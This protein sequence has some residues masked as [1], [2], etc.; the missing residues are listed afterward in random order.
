MRNRFDEQLM[1]LNRELIEMGSMCEEA[2]AEVAKALTTGDIELAKKIKADGSGIDHMERTIERRC[3][4]LLLHQQPV[5]RDL[6]LISAALKMITD[7]ERIGDMSE[8]IA[9]I[10]IELNGHAMEGM[11][12][13]LDMALETS[14]MVKSSVD[15][16]VKKDI[17]LAEAVIA[18]DDIVDDYFSKIKKGIIEIIANNVNDGEFVLDLLMIAK[19]FERIGDHAT[20]IA[21]WVIFSVTGTH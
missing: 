3:M 20:N 7:M 21:E 4:K 12:I 11:E 14:Q 9:E 8:D 19:Y 16:F 5:A 10:V 1:E 18:Q 17:V 15:A 13:V 2:I 6:R